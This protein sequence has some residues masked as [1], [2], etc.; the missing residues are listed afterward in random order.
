[1]EPNGLTR[2][3]SD[4]R[5][6]P[7]ALPRDGRPLPAAT[8]PRPR[9]GIARKVIA[10]GVR[11]GSRDRRHDASGDGG[12]SLQ[13]SAQARVDGGRGDRRDGFNRQAGAR[14]AARQDQRGYEQGNGS[15]RRSAPW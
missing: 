5:L 9:L 15:H 13:R 8:P 6:R 4:F 10:N 11:L 7:T 1:M 3:R 2:P 12:L 14:A